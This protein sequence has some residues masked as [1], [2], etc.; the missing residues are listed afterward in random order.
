[1]LFTIICL[2]G[3]A[4]E[5]S[6]RDSQ[7]V[8]SKLSELKK[9]PAENY[10]TEVDKYRSDLENYFDKKKRICDGEF[11]TVLI[12]QGGQSDSIVQ[13][14]VRLSRSERKICFRELKALQIRFVN[15]MYEARKRYLVYL[16]GRRLKDLDVSRADSIQ[17]LHSSF[18]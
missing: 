5:G 13:K 7:E 8:I 10:F 17:S 9:L 14:R 18:K 16:H 4:E 2:S 15:N 12:K 3:F 11:S 6:F 1:V